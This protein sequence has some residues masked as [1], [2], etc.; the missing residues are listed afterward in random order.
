M[1]REVRAKS[2][3][4]LGLEPAAE[5]EPTPCRPIRELARGGMGVIWDA[6]DPKL[7]RQV[8]MKVM[9]RPHAGAAERQRFIQEARVLG[10]LAHPNIVPVYDIGS[11]EHGRPCYTMK[12]VQGSTLQ[13]IFS[14]I[15]SGDADTI[16]AYPLP[17]LL[18][19]L[20]KVCDA[21]SFAHARG[22]IHRDLKPQ[23]IMVGEFGQVLVMDWGLAK[24][25]RQKPHGETTQFPD[26]RPDAAPQATAANPIVAHGFGL[27][28]PAPSADTKPSP[29]PQQQATDRLPPSTMGEPAERTLEGTVLGTPGYMAP[30]QAA[31]RL[32][33]VDQQSDVFSLAAILY[34]ILTLRPPV[35]GDNPEELLANARRGE[36]LPPHLREHERTTA[37][38]VQAGP[39]EAPRRRSGPSPTLPHLPGG[40][41]PPALAAVAMRGLAADRNRRYPS[42]AAFSADLAAYQ[43]GFAT[44][45][46]EAGALRQ[47]WLFMGRHHA[48]TTALAVILVL[49]I[50]FVARLIVSERRA[51]ENANAAMLSK[52]A[53]ETSTETARKALARSQVSL[54]EVAYHELDS[55][56]TIKALESV[57]RPYRDGDW[58]YLRQQADTSQSIL[59]A[60]R[61]F[62]YIGA[63]AHPRE[64]GLFALISTEPAL[65]LVDARTGQRRS[66]ITLTLK[67][68]QG[69]DFRGLAFSPDGG[70]LLLGG[71]GDEGVAIYDVASG[72]AIVAWD[73]PENDYVQFGSDGSR[74]LEI[75]LRQQ[76][77]VRNAATGKEL[78]SRERWYR[79]VFATA[80]Q[81]FATSGDQLVMLD[82]ATGEVLKSFP[83]AR[84][85]VFRLALTPDRSSVFYTT[86]TD[87]LVRGQRL[88]DGGLIFERPLTDA[89]GRWPS[90]ALSSDGRRVLGAVTD[91]EHKT[92]IRVW[93]ASTGIQLQTLC[94][95]HCPLE[96]LAINP[97]SDDV[98]TTGSESRSWSL[99]ERAPQWELAG[100]AQGGV[101]LGTDDL[102]LAAGRPIHLASPGRWD[103]QGPS[104]P[105]PFAGSLHLSS[106][107]GLGLIGI[108]S[109]HDRETLGAEYLLVRTTDSVTTFTPSRLQGRDQAAVRITPSPNQQLLAARNDYN[110]LSIHEAA[111]GRLVSQGVPARAL[112]SLTDFA[113]LSPTRL[114][115]IGSSGPRGTSD[116]QERVM[117]WEA[118]AG[119]PLAHADHPT[120]MDCLAVF[121]GGD[122][123]AEAGADKRVRIRDA[124]TLAVRHEFRVH[125]G[126]IIALAAHPTQPIL[127]TASADLSVRLWG[128]PAGQL[129]T[130]LP[131]SPSAPTIVHFS[132]SGNRL[133]VSDQR[134][135]LRIWNV[136]TLLQKHSAKER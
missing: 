133:A 101:F 42:V 24:Q 64:P 23:N 136:D 30:E 104:L 7:Q 121:P 91:E 110:E 22:I 37:T 108:R 63:A 107:K 8:A 126:P 120:A 117:L 82:A 16:A 11:D 59:D 80:D 73:S 44:R 9:K 95:H 65:H 122:T 132:P 28:G 47:L 74:T 15:R 134:G 106:T 19:V 21:M 57:P 118:P 103:N 46:E 78:W 38:H 62:L 33:E 112:R 55:R 34:A 90:V 79:A 111:S 51:K 14:R 99:A 6:R 93:D 69:H 10:Q 50:A 40:R 60:G 20:Q 39:T 98:V 61:G 131:R 48:H 87:T 41:V 72:R 84:G 88:G 36:I 4:A 56:T 109:S 27:E 58:A 115:G 29:N 70:R 105:P 68:S 43:G 35:R 67:Q 130:E 83:P 12:L 129:L 113:W 100:S 66:R 1:A 76:L 5:L 96:T 94:G 52:T 31:G 25:T 3:L 89:N 86:R 75:N 125:D 123:F 127:A 97:V 54:A 53:A 81:I 119:I 2:L 18:I 13:E 17:A 124:R 116:N 102:L 77:T 49:S 135:G 71:L 128:L 32:E 114:V 92:I 26:E 85:D 45:A